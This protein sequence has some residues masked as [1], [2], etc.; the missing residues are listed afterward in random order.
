MPVQHFQR[1]NNAFA[2][3]L[4]GQYH[5]N[6]QD[7]RFATLSNEQ[8]HLLRM[9]FAA[10]TNPG[11]FFSG[12]DQT[13]HIR[14]HLHSRIPFPAQCLSLDRPNQQNC[15][16]G[17]VPDHAT[18]ARGASSYTSEARPSKCLSFHFRV[19]PRYSICSSA[20]FDHRTLIAGASA[21]KECFRLP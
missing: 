20:S 12:R 13:L 4:D 11:C 7:C 16:Q 5:R 10:L 2:T 17:L 14:V 18:A 9:F 19:V 6:S 21:I 3:L 8:T 15:S 1:S